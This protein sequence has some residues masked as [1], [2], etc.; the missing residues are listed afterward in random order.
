MMLKSSFKNKTHKISASNSKSFFNSSF[1]YKQSIQEEVHETVSDLSCEQNV[2]DD[3]HENDSDIFYKND[4]DS[5]HKIFYYLQNFNI[6]DNF[7]FSDSQFM[8]LK[9]FCKH[10]EILKYLIN[11]I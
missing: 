1:F 2:F 3:F 8:F 9:K 6:Q 7:N 4:S 10:D 11:N 5:T